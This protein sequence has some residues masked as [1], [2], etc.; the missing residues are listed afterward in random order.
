MENY[1]P[2]LL[3]KDKKTFLRTDTKQLYR[4]SNFPFNLQTKQIYVT[5]TQYIIK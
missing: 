2:A 1:F 3:V 5:S 4:V